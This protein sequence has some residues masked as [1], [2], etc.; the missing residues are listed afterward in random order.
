MI[1]VSAHEVSEKRPETASGQRWTGVRARRPEL[2]GGRGRRLRV[3]RTRRGGALLH[4]HRPATAKEPA[5]GRL[6][7]TAAVT[8]PVRGHDL[9]SRNSTSI[10]VEPQTGTFARPRR[11]RWHGYDRRTRR[12]RDRY[13]LRG[14]RSGHRRRTEEARA[15]LAGHRRRCHGG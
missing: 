9:L 3:P 10:L 6:P 11:T 13:R 7:R 12:L 2:G 1:P 4:G 14:P 15:R 8:P 5:A